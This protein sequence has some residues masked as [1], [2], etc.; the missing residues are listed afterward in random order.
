MH[1]GLAVTHDRGIT[2]HA[3]VK[4]Q[5]PSFQLSQTP[6]PDAAAA[7]LHFDGPSTSSHAV[8][9]TAS[10]AHRH[11]GPPRVRLLCSALH[12]RHGHSASEQ[13][14]NA[15]VKTTRPAAALRSSHWVGGARAIDTDL[16]CRQACSDD[17]LA[18]DAITMSGR[19]FSV[20]A[21]AGRARKARGGEQ[22]N[23]HSQQLSRTSAELSLRCPSAAPG[24][25]EAARV[26]S[27]KIRSR[28][29]NKQGRWSS[30]HCRM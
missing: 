7:A 11:G 14:P 23:A 12:P 6:S 28:V 18:P 1:P 22:R 4:E 10:A 25:G 2:E 24:E 5:G 9:S 20:T 3:D 15:V 26:G 13:R 27:Q 21:T 29:I 17:R 30:E 19:W 16:A 8:E